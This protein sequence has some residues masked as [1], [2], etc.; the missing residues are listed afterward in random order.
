VGTAAAGNCC[1]ALERSEG[2]SKERIARRVLPQRRRFA[3]EV[4]ENGR[5][6]VARQL[7]R[8]RLPQ[9]RSVN[10]VRVPDD[11]FAERHFVGP[12]GV[13]LLQFGI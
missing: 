6:N 2:R 8:P 10:Q 1:S 13:F 12:G 11:N 7:R 3:P 9:R 5:G 4:G